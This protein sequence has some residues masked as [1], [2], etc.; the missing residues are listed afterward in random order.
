LG[1]NLSASS[2][3]RTFAKLIDQI[4]IARI[5]LFISSSE[6]GVSNKNVHV[7]S[8]S[9][10]SCLKLT[11]DHLFETLALNMFTQIEVKGVRAGIA[12]GTISPKCHIIILTY[13]G[14]KSIQSHQIYM[15]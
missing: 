10:H 12:Y 11:L 13:L 1:A 9:N 14:L 6:K 15:D 8:N 7:H 3:V 4:C 5:T 2:F